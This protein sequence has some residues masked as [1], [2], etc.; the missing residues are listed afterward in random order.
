M[1]VSFSQ[2]ADLTCPECGAATCPCCC[3]AKAPPSPSPPN[4]GA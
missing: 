2:R 4:S 3:R 1:A